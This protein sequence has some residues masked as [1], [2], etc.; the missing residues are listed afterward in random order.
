MNVE[1]MAGVVVVGELVNVGVGVNP[2]RKKNRRNQN[3]G[4]ERKNGGGV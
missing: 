1:F 4:E 2:G 3:S